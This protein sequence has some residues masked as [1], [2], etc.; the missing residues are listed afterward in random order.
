MTTN[1]PLEL[2]RELEEVIQVDVLARFLLHLPRFEVFGGVRARYALEQFYWIWDQVLQNTARWLSIRQLED[3][4]A[5]A[6][7]LG[8]GRTS[9]RE[10]H[11]PW[12]TRK[13]YR[14]PHDGRKDWKPLQTV[15]AVSVYTRADVLMDAA[16]A[17]HHFLIGR[18]SCAAPSSV[19]TNMLASSSSD[20]VSKPA[21]SPSFL[22]TLPSPL[23]FLPALQQPGW[24]LPFAASSI[25][26]TPPTLSNRKGQTATAGLDVMHSLEPVTAEDP[27]LQRDLVPHLQVQQSQPMSHVVVGG[28]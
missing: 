8:G 19:R 26:C 25:C 3:G 1:L 14:S 27:L 13:T 21:P 17:T 16:S 7:H 10:P 22:P 18:V 23:L 4:S 2:V 9:I 28:H 6:R 11:K 12:T 15:Y 20:S 5:A 24:L